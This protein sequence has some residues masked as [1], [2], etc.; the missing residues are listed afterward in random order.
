MENKTI[1][2]V[3]DALM[4]SNC[5]ACAAICPKGSISFR[6][7]VLGRMYAV[8]NDNC[9]D[10]GLCIKVCPSIDRLNMHDTFPDKYIGTIKT[11]HVG[12]STDQ[13]YYKN[14][15]S[16]GVCSTILDHLFETDAID[17]AI[18][19]K[20]SYGTPP[21]V[22]A[23]VINDRKQL[24][25]CQKS[26]YTPVELLSVLASED[27]SSRRI[28]IVGLPCHIQGAESLI[29]TLKRFSN[30]KYKIG[31]ICDRTLCGGISNVIMSYFPDKEA[32]IMWRRKDFTFNGKY[33]TYQNAPMSIIYKDGASYVMPAVARHAL[34]DYFTSPRCRV[35]YDKLNCFADI[36]LGDPWGMDGIDWDKGESVIATR[37]DIGKN[38]LDAAVM[39][40]RIVL[41]ESSI[42]EL[43][44]GQHI[45]ARRV[46]VSAYS[47]ALQVIPDKIDSYLYSQSDV[48]CGE[49]LVEKKEILDFMRR[50]SLDSES[51]IAESRRLV[52]RAIIHS[53]INS[54]LIVRILRK[55]KN[56]LKNEDRI[57]RN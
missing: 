21:I 27:I 57:I 3:S 10:C 41:R 25:E 32:R 12:K 13:L 52:D 14:G 24:Y 18:V 56:T 35:C 36:V 48:D 5:G 1:T 8:V 28:A 54:L 9:I 30:I 6:T 2:S 45:D 7:T 20:M 37:T 33:Y 53:R 16:G 23:V 43:V 26:C 22:K 19:C 34:K 4:C 15:Q 44:K 50:D 55:I 49:A 31:L 42:A 29:R 11:V 38:M 40:G 47:K 46:S 17:S 51:V 39:A